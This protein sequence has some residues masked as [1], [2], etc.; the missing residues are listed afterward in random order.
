MTKELFEINFRWSGKPSISVEIEC[1]PNATHS[2]K[3]RLAVINA[4]ADGADL[5]GVDLRGAIL[6]G[7]DLRGAYLRGADLRDAILR[8]ANLTGADLTGA[9][10][11]G[12][13]LWDT[14]GNGSHI[15]T[16]QT[17][18][19]MVVY[20]SEVIQ[21]GCE[22]HAIADWWNF[23]DEQIAEMHH[24]AL[25]WW[26]RWKPILQQIIETAPATPTKEQDND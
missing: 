24:G 6:S 20:T 7:V 26:E 9:D 3:L 25:E 13:G 22:C 23:D 14:L 21:I 11:S 19:W 8:R 15:R 18:R 10:L 12:V 16:L 2:V 4:I 5:S 17:D 1:E